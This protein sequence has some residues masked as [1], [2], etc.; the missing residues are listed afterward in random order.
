[1]KVHVVFNVSFVLILGRMGGSKVTPKNR[2]LESK[3]RT[4]GQKSSKI[5]G[6]HLWMFPY[7]NNYKMQIKSVQMLLVYLM[8]TPNS[9]CTNLR[10][11]VNFLIY[12]LK[13]CNSKKTRGSLVGF[14]FGLKIRNCEKEI[15]FLDSGL[16]VGI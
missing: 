12:F 11:E 9:E 15:K 5:V 10:I 7:L 6:H 1:M 14:L 16:D 8:P 3:N 4:G 13:S 2:T